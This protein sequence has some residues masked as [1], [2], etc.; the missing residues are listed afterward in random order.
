M[1]T[2]VAPFS[3]VGKP[4]HSGNP[5]LQ[6]SMRQPN[7]FYEGQLLNF[8]RMYDLERGSVRSTGPTDGMISSKG[9]PVDHGAGV[10]V[11]VYE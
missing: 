2:R 6:S 10:S 3:G 7:R 1:Y 5:C 9:G 8:V 11:C 4:T